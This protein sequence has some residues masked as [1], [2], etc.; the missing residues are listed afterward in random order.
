MGLLNI[1]NNSSNDTE[2]V[3]H[4]DFTARASGVKMAKA[5]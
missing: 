4:V 5:A 2:N 3:I 1:H